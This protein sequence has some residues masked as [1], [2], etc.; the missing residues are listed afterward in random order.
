MKVAIA[1]LLLTA[2]GVHAETRAL[3]VDASLPIPPLRTNAA[4]E[5]LIEASPTSS[6]SDF[7]YLVGKWKLTNKKLKCRLNG[8]TEWSPVFESYVDMEKVLG[9]MG[10]TDQYF[11]NVSGKPFRGLALRLF[12]PTTRLWSIYWVDGSRGTMDPPVVGSFSGGVGHFF[13]RDT[14]QG[15]PIVVVFRWDVRN[16]EFPVW[17]QAFSADGGKTWEWNSINVSERIF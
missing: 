17:S 4:G 14:Y 12:D 7:D 9:G 3:S 13:G 10:N 1:L 16:P 15:R 2:S 5:L 6:V 11:E 8:C